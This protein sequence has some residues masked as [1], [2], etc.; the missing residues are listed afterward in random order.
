MVQPL[1]GKRPEPYMYGA[2]V[3]EGDLDLLMLRSDVAQCSL[4]QAYHNASS[5]LD[6]SQPPNPS[7]CVETSFDRWCLTLK[8]DGDHF[9]LGSFAKLNT[10]HRLRI[11]GQGRIR[12]Y[13]Q[14]SFS[15]ARISAHSYS[16]GTGTPRV[17]CEELVN[18]CWRIALNDLD[19][20]V[21]S[22][23]SRVAIKKHLWK[24][25]TTIFVGIFESV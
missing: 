19:C 2:S 20:D 9:H 3:G 1:L 22:F 12:F 7:I 11:Y 13:V 15:H 24:S 23:S 6:D 21:R 14:S 8:S 17:G 18:T 16:T 25:D 4:P 10:L 5:N